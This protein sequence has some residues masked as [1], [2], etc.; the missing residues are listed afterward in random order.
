MNAIDASPKV[1]LLVE[2]DEG[3][4]ELERRALLRAGMQVRTAK[5]VSEAMSLLKEEAFLAVLLDYQ[6]PDGD[7]WQ[8]VDAAKAQ[9]PP[10][11]VILVTGMGNEKVA[12]E[13]IHRGVTD[14]V[15]KVDSFW[16]Q[17]PGAIARSTASS[18]RRISCKC[19]RSR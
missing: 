8:V 7:P 4:A 11:P 17:L 2:D 16:D 13:A 3:A 19:C 6:L 18:R 5:S 1:V 10:V 9:L 14:Y 15:K 12:A